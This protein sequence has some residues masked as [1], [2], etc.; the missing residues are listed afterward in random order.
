MDAAKKAKRRPMSGAERTA[1]LRRF[2]PGILV[3]SVCYMCIITFRSYRDYF[4]LD[5]YKA[6]LGRDPDPWLYLV[7]DFPA[8]GLSSLIMLAMSRITDNRTAVLMLHGEWHDSPLHDSSMRTV[9]R[10]RQTC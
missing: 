7:A 4:A 8:G 10:H 1:F 5:I 2:W 3:I 6:V 9:I